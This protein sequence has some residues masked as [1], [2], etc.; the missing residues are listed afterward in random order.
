MSTMSKKGRKEGRKEGR[1]KEKEEKRC[2][3]RKR[4]KGN[5]NNNNNKRQEKKKKKHILKLCTLLSKFQIFT[6][7][8]SAERKVSPSQFKLTELI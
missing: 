4:R 1:K 3:V 8:S 2:N 6:R 7:R 5:N